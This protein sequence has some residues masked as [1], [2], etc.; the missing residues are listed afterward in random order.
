MSYFFVIPMVSTVQKDCGFHR[1]G[2]EK[3]R[4][5]KQ[6]LTLLKQKWYM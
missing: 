2:G 4:S 1:R 6:D 3:G 5:V